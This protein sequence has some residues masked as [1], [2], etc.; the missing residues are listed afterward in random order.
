VADRLEL[1]RECLARARHRAREI[2][3][4]LTASEDFD[5]FGCPGSA[6]SEL[7]SEH[8]VLDEWLAKPRQQQLRSLI[9][10]SDEDIFAWRVGRPGSQPPLTLRFPEPVMQSPVSRARAVLTLEEIVA[11]MEC[12]R[13]FLP[14]PKP[15]KLPSPAGDVQAWLRAIARTIDRSGSLF[16]L[17]EAAI[18]LRFQERLR[19]AGAQR[20]LEGDW[21]PVVRI[22]RP[23]RTVTSVTQDVV[24]AYSNTYGYFHDRYVR[25]LGPGGLSDGFVQRGLGQLLREI[26]EKFGIKAGRGR[27]KPY[28]AGSHT[29]K[30]KR[31]GDDGPRVSQSRATAAAKKNDQRRMRRSKETDARSDEVSKRAAMG[32]RGAISAGG[33]RKE[34]ASADV[35]Q[36]ATRSSKHEGHGPATRAAKS[37]VRSARSKRATPPDDTRAP[38]LQRGKKRDRPR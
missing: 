19:K 33:R 5:V 15:G 12:M 4:E 30:P 26:N 13:A 37:P 17:E 22:L 38:G 20:L 2:W 7:A 31:S 23:L 11:W 10:S 32:R 29:E 6:I 36:S 8:G 16:R 21:P 18:F 27:F 24:D 3:P 9:G 1:D 25:V 34:D 14:S 28:D 35:G